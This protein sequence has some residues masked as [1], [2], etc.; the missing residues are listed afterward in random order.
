MGATITDGPQ[1]QYRTFPCPPLL[2]LHTIQSWWST[3]RSQAQ[4]E[5]AT[6][7]SRGGSAKPRPNINAFG[8]LLRAAAHSLSLWWAQT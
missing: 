3:K 7:G 5:A 6:M 8:M 4:V 2:L 1:R